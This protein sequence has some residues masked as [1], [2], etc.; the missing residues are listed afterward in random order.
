MYKLYHDKRNLDLRIEP[1][2]NL[3]IDTSKIGEMPTI[4][5]DS[6][7]V[8]NNRKALKELAQEIKKNWINEYT[9]LLEMTKHTEIKNKY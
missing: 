3:L 7:Y 2:G 6:Y 4:F 8:C 1:L 5:N 9:D